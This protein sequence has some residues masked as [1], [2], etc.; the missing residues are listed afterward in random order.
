MDRHDADLVACAVGLPLD[1]EFVGLHPHQK[2]RQ[3]VDRA[4]LVGQGLRQQRVDSVLGLGSEPAEQLPAALMDGEDSLKQVVR[5]EEVDLGAQILENSD[6]L[7]EV[8]AALAKGPPQKA[9]AI[10]GELVQLGL[11]PAEQRRAQ[12]RCERQVVILERQKRQ[13]RLEVAHRD[14][15]RDLEPVGA[16]DRQ[17]RRLA[18]AD[19]VVKQARP[20]LHEHEDVARP[21]GTGAAVFVGKRRADHVADLL[22]DALGEQALRVSRGPDVDGIVPVGI[23]RR[24]LALDR[25]PQVDAP[26]QRGLEGDVRLVAGE[27]AVGA[28]LESGVHHRQDQRRGAEGVRHRHVLQRRLRICQMLGELVLHPLEL[29]RIGSLEGV[30]R[31]LLVADYE[32]GARRIAV[33]AEAA[34]KLPGE[35]GD[36]LPLFRAGV[37][38]LVDQDVIDPPVDL[39]EHPFGQRL[40][41]QQFAGAVDQI[42]EVQP[43][44]R[45]LGRVVLWKE[46]GGKGVQVA[47]PVHQPKGEARLAGRLDARHPVVEPF[48][49]R[50]V[51][52][53]DGLAGK[54]LPSVLRGL[55]RERVGRARSGQE[56]PLERRQVGE[57]DHVRLRQ[58]RELFGGGGVSLAAAIEDLHQLR[59]DGA[60]VFGDGALGD[61]RLAEIG[62]LAEKLRQ[63]LLVQRP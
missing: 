34:R 48:H 46:H 55:C 60:S 17:I 23:L 22:R 53:A 19:D 27:S 57:S 10:M 59:E 11:R 47:G 62:R 31:L 26:R 6:R 58:R 40:V 7:R 29:P 33:G 20:P 45:Q 28:G 41:L 18:L 50:G 42:V 63:R 13:Q 49:Q 61:G 43:S 16:R 5:S 14:L 36:H 44:P 9:L 32:E 2:S 35:A 21:C 30:D 3:A 54:E 25:I 39:E 52:V 37:L 56:N 12:G 1:L 4:A 51:R 15:A 38:G 24:V 8:V